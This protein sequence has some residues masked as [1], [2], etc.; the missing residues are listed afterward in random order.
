MIHLVGTLA[1]AA[2]DPETF[3]ALLRNRPH[4]EFELLVGLLEMIVFDGI[5]GAR[6]YPWASRHIKHHLLR[7]RREIIADNVGGFTPFKYR[8]EVKAVYPSPF[9]WSRI[10]PDHFWYVGTQPMPDEFNQLPK[11]EFDWSITTTARH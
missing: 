3:Q 9:D 11:G 2:P 5:I 6:L 4:W 10:N 1:A 8:W 7:D